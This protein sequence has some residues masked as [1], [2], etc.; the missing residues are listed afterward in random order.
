[1]TRVLLDTNVILDVLLDRAPHA[2][3]STGVLA[4]A[5]RGGIQAYLCASAVDTLDYLLSKALGTKASRRHLHTL[6][7]IV[8]IAPV[9]QVVVDAALDRRWPDLE[10]AIVHESAVHA[11]LDAIITRNTKDFRG[12]SLPLYT[13]AEFLASRATGHE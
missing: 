2:D 6:R 4:L 11:G 13:P 10:D 7:R 12:A 8:Q 1:M 3:A 9:D 5:E